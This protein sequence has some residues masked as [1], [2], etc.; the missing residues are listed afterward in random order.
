MPK[1]YELSRNADLWAAGIA[2]AILFALPIVGA[3]HRGSFGGMEVVVAVTGVATLAVVVE[4]LM[5][6][7]TRSPW[8]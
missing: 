4:G 3:L 2:G 8:R 1:Y 7:R 5:R 6:R